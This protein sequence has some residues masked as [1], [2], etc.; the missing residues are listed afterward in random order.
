MALSKHILS[1]PRVCI[2]TPLL[3]LSAHHH[4]SLIPCLPRPASS[5]FAQRHGWSDT[6]FPVT[7][8]DVIIIT[9][10]LIP[11][12]CHTMSPNS[13]TPM[14]WLLSPRVWHLTPPARSLLVLLALL[15]F[16]GPPSLLRTAQAVHNRPHQT[17]PDI[18]PQ[19]TTHHRS[20]PL[21]VPHAK[22]LDPSASRQCT[23]DLT[24][25]SQAVPSRRP[26]E[27]E[28]GPGKGHGK[29]RAGE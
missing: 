2:R 25:S 9:V 1:S 12:W 18:T 13:K 3:P 23:V 22:H 8:H 27:A 19:Q 21:H 15:V 26:S 10:I 28:E 5:A 16:A 14:H 24:G 7:A 29:V 6:T 4:L 17:T 11:L 20:R